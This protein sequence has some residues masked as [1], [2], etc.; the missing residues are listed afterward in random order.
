MR[1]PTAPTCSLT[2]LPQLLIHE[3]PERPELCVIEIFRVD[4][5]GDGS[6]TG[7]TKQLA[8][9]SLQDAGLCL[10]YLGIRLVDKPTPDLRPRQQ[11][12]LMEP[13][14]NGHHRGVRQL[15]AVLR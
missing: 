2:P 4:E 1:E 6:Q 3:P 13:A 12:F 7:S 15:V 14:Q 9:N 11:T 10:G 5:R 8:V